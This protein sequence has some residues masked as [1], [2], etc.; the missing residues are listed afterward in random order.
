MENW[1]INLYET[2]LTQQTQKSIATKM[3]GLQ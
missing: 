3:I 1:N 2:I